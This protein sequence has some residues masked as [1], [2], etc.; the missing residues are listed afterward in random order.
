MKK[1]FLLSAAM[2]L[3]G[4][5]VFSQNDISGKISLETGGGWAGQVLKVQGE[6]GS[7][8]FTATGSSTC[9][10]MNYHINNNWGLSLEMN[11]Q[12][13]SF[14]EADYFGALNVADGGRYK[15]GL[16]EWWNSYLSQ[17][18]SNLMLGGFYR[19]QHKRFTLVP[20]VSIGISFP[21]TMNFEYKRISKSGD[22]GPEYFYIHSPK[23]EV[24]DFL[25]NSYEE[26]QE[27]R[28]LQFG[29]SCQLT[30][31]V[32]KRLYAYVEP[33]LNYSPFKLSVVCDHYESKRYSEPSNWVEAVDQGAYEQSLIK[34]E[35]SKSSTL[36]KRS[37]APF[38]YVNFGVGISF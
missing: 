24:N 14:S 12:W 28:L 8:L 3:V 22:S 19:V 27:E 32:F 29:A 38:F 25:I 36:K 35:A 10:R 16:Y 21:S 9:L 23:V 18:Q 31:K 15:Y 1:T 13:A 7:D 26:Y 37:F 4:I 6:Q 33:G 30:Y 2:L 11:Y 20:R 34:D 5:P 17:S